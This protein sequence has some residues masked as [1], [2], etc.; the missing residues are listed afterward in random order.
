MIRVLIVDD[1]PII[2][3]G[4]RNHLANRDNYEVIGAAATDKSSIY[5]GGLS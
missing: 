5:C 3:R 1:E 4:L 2:R